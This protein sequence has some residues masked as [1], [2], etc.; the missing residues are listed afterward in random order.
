MNVQRPRKRFGQHFLTRDD[1]VADIVAAIAAKPQETLIE[2]GPGRGALTEPLSREPIRL[3]AIE[4]DRDLVGTLRRRFADSGNVTIHQGDALEFDYASLG[5]ELRIVGNLPYNIST[6]LMFSLIEARDVIVDLHFMLQKEVVDR[7][8]A[9]PGSKNYGRLTIMLGC[10]LESIALFDV[11]PDA[12][13]PPPKVNSAVLRMRPRADDSFSIDDHDALARLVAIPTGHQDWSI[14]CRRREALV[15]RRQLA[16]GSSAR[17][18]SRNRER[19]HPGHRDPTRRRP[20]RGAGCVRDRN[21]GS[22]TTSP[23]RRS[24][25][26]KSCLGS[27]P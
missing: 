14:L 24:N 27:P 11:P 13:S 23:A 26:G 12:F 20:L 9:L 4:F 3:H 18:A 8:C 15:Y 2:I 16:A 21:P 6:P 7:I 5:K 17:P 22:A 10:Y 19:G 25:S 1:I